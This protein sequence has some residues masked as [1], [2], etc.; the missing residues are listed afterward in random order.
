MS[1][2]LPAQAQS[3]SAIEE[4]RYTFVLVGVSL[5]EALSLLIDKTQIS[6]V[7]GTE[8]VEGKTTFCRARQE[9]QEA[10]LACILKAT[11]LDYSRLSSG[12]YVLFADPQTRPRYGRLVWGLTKSLP[13]SRTN[14]PRPR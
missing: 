1:C 7:Y 11:G 9:P 3:G 14:I 6:L 8:L 13:R 12:T 4:T 10:V 5:V 2:T